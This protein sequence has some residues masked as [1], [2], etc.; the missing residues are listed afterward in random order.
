MDNSRF[1]YSTVDD[2]RASRSLRGYNRYIARLFAGALPPGKPGARPQMLDFG[3]GIGTIAALVEAETGCRPLTLDAD[4]DHAARLRAQG[5]AVIDRLDELPDGA[6]D[7]VYSSNVLEHIDDDRAALALLYRKLRP[8]GTLALYVPA[9]MSLWSRLDELAGHVRRYT[10]ADLAEKVSAA[11][12]SIT[13]SQY[14]DCLG[15]IAT[16]L[17]RR[18]VTVAAEMSA[19]SLYV[20]D[21][22]LF[23]LSRAGDALTGRRF[24]KNLFLVARRPG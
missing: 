20:F 23:P 3:A 22:V 6:L 18:H 4:P 17:F 11:G 2:L 19:Q 15:F 1:R 12:F 5:F 7:F 10:R 14:C 21:R 8:G 16:C 13:H 24:G 9:F